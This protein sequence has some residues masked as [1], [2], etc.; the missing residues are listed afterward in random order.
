MPWAQAYSESKAFSEG[1]HLTSHLHHA[2]ICMC[3]FVG[4]ASLFCL[5]DAAYNLLLH[6][7]KH[8]TQLSGSIILHHPLSADTSSHIN[9]CVRAR[10]HTCPQV[11][12]PVPTPASHLCLHLHPLLCTSAYTCTHTCAYTCTHT[13]APVPASALQMRER[14]SVRCPSTEDLSCLPLL[15]FWGGRPSA[16]GEKEEQRRAAQWEQQQQLQREQQLER[17]GRGGGQGLAR[18]TE[19]QRS[20]ASGGVGGG[21]TGA[22]SAQ[23]VLFPPS[24]S[25]PQGKL[26]SQVCVCVVCMLC[27]YV[28]CVEAY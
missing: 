18:L 8:A 24:S 13:C 27:V 22:G 21:G 20:G 23:W 11:P 6:M 7:S 16:A 10:A 5:Q 2:P 1:A 28:L 17:E 15:R 19:A 4:P 14:M 9:T 26:S 12:L 25:R 3:M